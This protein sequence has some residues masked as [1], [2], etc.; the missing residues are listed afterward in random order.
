MLLSK[1]GNLGPQPD[2]ATSAPIG[3]AE[4]AGLAGR[5]LEERKS[6]KPQPSHPFSLEMRFPPQ[7]PVSEKPI[8]R[9]KRLLGLF[10]I[11]TV[12]AYMDLNVENASI[13][14]STDLRDWIG[15]VE[16]AETTLPDYYNVLRRFTAQ[17][18]DSHIGISLVSP[19]PPGSVS[20]IQLRPIESKPVVV[21]TLRDAA[22]D[23]PPIQVGDEILTINGKTVEELFAERRPLISA[24]TPGAML[25]NLVN[26]LMGGQGK[27]TLEVTFQNESGR[28][29]VALKTMS[30]QWL[31]GSGR[32]PPPG[33]PPSYKILDGGFG[34]INLDTLI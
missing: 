26:S 32:Q 18:N 21:R 27:D 14:W 11:W 8:S 9:E 28:H 7:E 31:P 12:I 16:E 6:L 24:S 4:L 23:D 20:P 17:L 22:G 3:E 2:Y 19:L 15:K 25:R 30:P 33:T 10:K 1:R 13:D 34:Y 29:T 5:L